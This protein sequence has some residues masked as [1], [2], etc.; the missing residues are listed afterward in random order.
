MPNTAQLPEPVLAAYLRWWHGLQSPQAGGSQRAAR[1]QLK[2]CHSVAA[3][4]LEPA[5]QQLYQ[6]LRAA[7]GGQ[8]W[9]PFQQDRLAALAALGAHV[10]S[11]NDLAFPKAASQGGEGGTAPL[12]PLRFRRLLDADDIES[13]FVGLRRALP[14]IGHTLSPSQ[15]AKDVF[16]WGDGVKRRWAYAYAWPAESK[17]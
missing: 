17:S 5:F 4:A 9:P 6:Q 10:Q 12:S 15:L 2:R 8:D 7:Y 1:A 16:E 13:L 14:L 11:A 3:V